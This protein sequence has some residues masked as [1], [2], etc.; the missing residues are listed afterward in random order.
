MQYTPTDAPRKAPST[1]AQSIIYTSMA[2]QQ[3]CLRQK[4]DLTKQ[5]NGLLLMEFTDSSSHFFKLDH[6]VEL[7]CVFHQEA[8]D[9]S[10]AQY[11]LC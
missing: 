7:T 9:D 6:V 2:F 3:H 11:F 5:D 10:L 4:D 8:Y 1:A